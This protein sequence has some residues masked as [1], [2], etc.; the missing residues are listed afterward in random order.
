MKRAL[1]VRWSSSTS[2]ASAPPRSTITVAA[3]RGTVGSPGLNSSPGAVRSVS[4]AAPI[5]GSLA[6]T[7]GNRAHSGSA[8]PAGSSTTPRRATP[9]AAS[10]RARLSRTSPTTGTAPSAA[11]ARRTSSPTRTKP[12]LWFA[13][14][15]QAAGAARGDG[16]RGGE[17]VHGRA[18]PRDLGRLARAGGE[19]RA[20]D[21]RGARG[22]RRAGAALLG[23]RVG[24]RGA[25]RRA[26]RAGRAPAGRRARRRGCGPFNS[27]VRAR[28]RG[29]LGAL[30][31]VLVAAVVLAVLAFEVWFFLSPGPIR[32]A[33][34][35]RC[36]AS[37]SPSATLRSGGG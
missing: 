21:D 23:A 10:R 34:Q 12:R 27:G 8:S 22:D 19:R 32:F 31:V 36:S 5:L 24:A 14:A 13:H 9:T 29:G 16:A 33:C 26:R 6:M 28:R 3:W 30:D 17:P 4:I 15:G 7:H 37:H 35:A 1:G 20:L 11:R 18:A 2:S 25:R